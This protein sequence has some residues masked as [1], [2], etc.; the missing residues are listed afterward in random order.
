MHYPV[1]EI[2][3]LILSASMLI[4]WAAAFVSASL[5]Y[6]SVLSFRRGL[7]FSMRMYMAV[8][9]LLFSF[10]AAILLQSWF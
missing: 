6:D 9:V 1:I 8:I 10:V 5:S 3:Q 7:A 4:A 2:L